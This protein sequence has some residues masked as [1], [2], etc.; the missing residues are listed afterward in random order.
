MSGDWLNILIKP[1]DRSYSLPN[2]KMAAQR[3]TYAKQWRATRR[4][5]RRFDTL[6]S[7]YLSVKYSNIREEIHQLYESLN[8]K[9]PTKH[10]LTKTKE[11]RQWKEQTKKTSDDHGMDESNEAERGTEPEQE[12]SD[13]H[14]MDESNEAE[15]GTEPEQETSDDHGMDESNEAERGTEPEQE[16]SDDH[17]MD[18]SNEAERGTEPEQETSDDHGMDESNEAE[19]GTEPEQE[20]SD[21]RG[22]PRDLLQLAGAG[23]IP[24][25]DLDTMENIISDIVNELQQDDEIRNIFNDGDDDN[26]VQPHYADEDEGL[27]LDFQVELDANTEPFDF[28]LEV[29][30][31]EW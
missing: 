9:Y 16:T 1:I 19:R 31:Y 10:D 8:T 21:D 25:Y 12:T 22:T 15:R 18:E 7:D 27:G 20:T 23:L 6:A 26:H 13:D 3:A 17:G 14:G 28:A 30:P 2:A 24:Q 29:E 5:R 4:Q 11:F